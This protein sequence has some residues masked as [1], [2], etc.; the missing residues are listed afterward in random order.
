LVPDGRV[1]T[2]YW[3]RQFHHV[4]EASCL[5]V[6]PDVQHLHESFVSARNRFVFENAVKF[7]LVR[8]VLLESR[9]INDFDRA[10]RAQRIARQPN[11]AISTGANAVQKIVIGNGQRH[12]FRFPLLSQ[13][14][15]HK[16]PH[17]VPRLELVAASRG[18]RLLRGIRHGRFGI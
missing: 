4:V 7:A 1:L 17:R 13:L 11:F 18:L 16:G 9:A 10:Q 5:I 2:G 3:V 15:L 14:P 8:S 12:M 6:S